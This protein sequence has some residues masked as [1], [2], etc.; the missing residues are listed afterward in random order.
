MVL[1]HR[2]MV[3]D[4][5]RLVGVARRL[6]ERGN[7]VHASDLRRYCGMLLAV[8]EHHHQGEDDFLWP[9]V[10]QRGGDVEALRLMTTE[11]EELAA[12]LHR[13]RDTL[14][15]LGENGQGA[16]QLAAHAEELR[17]LVAGHA[18]DEERELLGRL[19]PALDE[20]VWKQFEKNMIRS[21]P[22]WTLRFMPPW[23]DAVAGEGDKG[24]VPL[25]LLARGFRGW[26]RRQ[27][28]HAFGDL[29]M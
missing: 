28:R 15:R 20:T 10:E 19:A 2:A 16:D 17:G 11:H 6:T 14:D 22:L 1:A 13:V 5:E 3:G 24:G 4:L 7:V 21:A 27:R 18:A 25:P 26:L 29:Q 8:V 23:L 12:A 9:R